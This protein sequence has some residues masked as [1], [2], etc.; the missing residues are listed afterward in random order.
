MRHGVAGNG[1]VAGRGGF[2][3]FGGI[4]GRGVVGRGGVAGRGRVAGCGGVAGHRAR[5]SR[6]VRWSRLERGGI[7]ER[8]VT[9]AV[10]VNDDAQVQVQVRAPP[11]S[12]QI[13]AE[14]CTSIET[15][16]GRRCPSSL[17]FSAIGPA[18]SAQS[19]A[20]VCLGMR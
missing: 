13:T 10:D 8:R 9:D 16:R 4:A 14:T 11:A 3:E 5:W 1:G 19:T 20:K 18:R 17:C 12:Q 2:V 15:P 6:R 7:V